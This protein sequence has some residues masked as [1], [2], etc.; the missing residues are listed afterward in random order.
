MLVLRIGF[1]EVGGAFAGQTLPRGRHPLGEANSPA[2][3][4]IV[5]VPPVAFA[6]VMA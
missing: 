2:E 5:F 6:C 4:S 1:D 3:K